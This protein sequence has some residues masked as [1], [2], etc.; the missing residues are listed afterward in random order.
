MELC[1]GANCSS[2]GTVDTSS[3][4]LQATKSNPY[5]SVVGGLLKPACFKYTSGDAKELRGAGS[6]V[7]DADGNT[8]AVCKFGVRHWR[9]FDDDRKFHYASSCTKDGSNWYLIPS[10]G[11]AVGNTKSATDG[12]ITTLV[13]A[14]SSC[15]SNNDCEFG[16]CGGDGLCSP[17]EFKSLSEASTFAGTGT[18]GSDNGSGTTAT[19]NGPIGICIAPDGKRTY[20]VDA[21]AHCIRSINNEVASTSTNYIATPCGTCGTSGFTIGAC[22]TTAL[23]NTPQFCAVSADNN[24]VFVT[25]RLNHAVSKI[26]LAST[27]NT[28]STLAGSGASGFANGSGSG[29]TFNSPKQIA[30]DSSDNLYIVDRDNHAIRKVTS[31]GVCT[32]VAGTGVAGNVNGTGT[33]ASFDT[34]IGVVLDP[35]ETFL[36][37]TDS[38]N[39]SIRKINLATSVVTTFV[40][41]L[42]T[43]QARGLSFDPWGSNLVIANH[44]SIVKITSTG[45]VTTLSG[46]ADTSGDTIGGLTS[47][48]FSDPGGVFFSPS[49]NSLFIPDWGNNKIRLLQ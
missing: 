37:V 23:M 25:E 40:S 34:P 21:T 15:S 5:I 12:D 1:A 11:V 43:T 47:S 27:G 13:S 49:G 32:T 19:F 38:H 16:F 10:S 22:A 3:D 30:V 44:H 31:A 26:A 28:L 18:A 17:K 36:Y 14:N 41:G 42:S 48:R 46:N 39:S 7:T 29:C 33:A 4:G 8:K 6:W 45:S 2:P 24:S 20:V 35:T 9:Q